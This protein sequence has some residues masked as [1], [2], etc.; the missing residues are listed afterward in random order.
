MEKTLKTMA[1]DFYVS[2]PKF[3]NWRMILLIISILVLLGEITNGT[4]E[5][6]FIVA[7][8]GVLNYLYFADF[9]LA[10]KYHVFLKKNEGASIVQLANHLGKPKDKVKKNLKRLI[11]KNI[12]N[13]VLLD[14]NGETVM[15]FFDDS[16]FQQAYAEDQ[17]RKEEEEAKKAGYNSAQEKALAEQKEREKKAYLEQKRREA[18]EKDKLAREEARKVVSTKLIHDGIVQETQSKTKMG[19]MAGRAIV[20]G[21]LLGPAGAIIGGATAK[22]K[23]DSHNVDSGKRTFLVQYANGRVQEETV[24]VNSAKYKEYMSKLVM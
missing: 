24:Q 13:H 5:T 23:I 2:K 17:N 16:D 20:G 7:I 1:D 22:K 11:E 12:F 4:C 14:E 18:E 8:M 19:S 3:F 15:Y 9:S 21:A 6:I 10:K